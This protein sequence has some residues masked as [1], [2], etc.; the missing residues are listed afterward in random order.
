MVALSSPGLRL[1]SADGELEALRMLA[2]RYD[3][4][5]KRRVQTVNRLHRLIAELVPGTRKKD[6]SDLQAKA[7]LTTVRPRDL[8]GTTRRRMAGE[9]LAD[10]V[11]TDSQIK[12]IKADL[13]AAIAERG[14]TLMELS[15]IGP[16]G[17]A[18]VLA[19]VGDVARFANRN[20]FA[21]WTGTAPLDASSGEQIR[22]RLSPAAAG[23][24]AAPASRPGRRRS[25]RSGLPGSSTETR[26]PLSGT[27]FSSRTRP[28]TLE[29]TGP[30]SE[31]CRRWSRMEEAP[32]TPALAGR[33]TT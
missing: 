10:L 6:L 23:S 2:D 33:T 17:A 20:R 28:V 30:S 21:S 31:I 13:K 7:I 29:L 32:F 14:S 27:E 8:A 1:L 12:T 22:H 5:S 3:E 25:G 16:V 9:E 15:G 18:R 24:A 19:D 11:R 4:L 26:S